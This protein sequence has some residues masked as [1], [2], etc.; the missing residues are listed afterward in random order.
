MNKHEQFVAIIKEE[1]IPAFG[2]TEPIAVAY[3]CALAKKILKDEPESVNVYC[4]GNIVKNVKGVV[5][6]NSGNLKGLKT[7][8]FQLIT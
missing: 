2:C 8:Y 1:L 4:S 3:A 5:V 6:P 7:R